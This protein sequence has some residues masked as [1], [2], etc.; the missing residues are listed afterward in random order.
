M[1]PSEESVAV[2]SVFGRLT[3][4]A[5]LAHERGHMLTSQAGLD[6]EGG[7]LLDEVQ[8]SLVARQQRGL[9]N[10]ER[11]QLLRD[12]V[13]RARVEGKDLRTLLPQLKYF[14]K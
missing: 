4:R 13:E 14:W 8:A 11:M 10:Q 9:S 1:L 3:P 2:R 12:A 7:S 6:F 5:V